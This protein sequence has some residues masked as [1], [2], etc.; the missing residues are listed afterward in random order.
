MCLLTTPTNCVET[1]NEEGGEVREGGLCGNCL[2]GGN[3]VQ[4]SASQNCSYQCVCFTDPPSVSHSLMDDHQNYT[5][6]K[7]NPANIFSVG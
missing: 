6:L 3:E 5:T 2:S 1:L 7:C 4:I